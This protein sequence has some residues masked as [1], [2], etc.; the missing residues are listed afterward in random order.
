MLARSKTLA[1]GSM[2]MTA[3]WLT[4]AL[5]LEEDEK[6]EMGQF[7]REYL[8][9]NPEVML[10]VQA[11]LEAKQH[12]QR[13]E[14]AGQAVAANHDAIF[15]SQDDIALG[16]PDGDVT[17]VEFFDYNCGYCKRALADM[18]KVLSTDPKVRFVLKELPILGPDSLDAHRVSNAVRLIAPEKYGE[19]HRALLGSTGT[20]TEESAIE[21]AAALGI[22]EADLRKS[23]A[24]NP[25]DQLVRDAYTL[26][27]NLGVTGTPTYI[28]GNEA[29][30]GAVGDDALQE[31][32]ANVR[33]CGKSTC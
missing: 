21:V 15:N 5:A 22:S 19:F 1:L 11:A 14:Q 3:L 24:E 33:A 18:E 26:A 20:A 29:L 12:S 7:I 30:F 6:K 27:T 25:N 31:K 10:E 16:N 23:M 2:L 13:L 4:P 9:E 28:V 17:V 8:L 32:I